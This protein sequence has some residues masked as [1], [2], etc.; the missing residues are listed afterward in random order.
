MEELGAISLQ[1]NNGLSGDIDG[2]G[3]P[4]N[5]QTAPRS[6]RNHIQVHYLP[7]R[8]YPTDHITFGKNALLGRL[9]RA[10]NWDNERETIKGLTDQIS[11]GLAA[12]PSTNAFS[13]HLRKMEHSS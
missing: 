1:C 6:D 11:E 10:V 8:R 9:L 5:P 12:K 7:A 4:L 2:S 3:S 13:T